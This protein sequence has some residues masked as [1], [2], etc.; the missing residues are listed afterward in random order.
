MQTRLA[1]VDDDAVLGAIA[2][3]AWSPLHAVKQ[4]P[5]DREPFFSERHR[6]ED[7]IVA[8][9]D[10]RV[11]GYV[12]V[13]PAT[14]HASNAHVQQVQRLALEEWA[15]GHGVGRELMKQ[16]I[17]LAQERGARRLTLRVLGHNTPARQ[18]Y[19]AMGSV[20]EGVLPG[21]FLLDGEYVDD[22]LMGLHL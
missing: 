16:A 20:I 7:T 3:R 11:A 18:L 15:R 19:E 21:E 14:P 17:E 2:R 6:P 10:G 13:A 4:R 1:A 12:A 9:V 5:M 22:V 8:E